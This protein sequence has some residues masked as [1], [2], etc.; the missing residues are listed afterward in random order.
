LRTRRDIEA[1]AVYDIETEGWSKFLVGGWF[2][3]KTYLE[4]DWT[5]EEE[6]RAIVW[7]GPSPTW[8]HNGGVFDH[9]WALDG[10]R[11]APV[12]TR[13]R[14]AGSRLVE[15]RRGDQRLLD[16]KAIAKLSLDR[17]TSGLGVT[18]L[19]QPLACDRREMH[20]PWCRG[21][22]RFRRGMLRTDFEKVREYLRADCESLWLALGRLRDWAAEHDLDLA[23]TIGS[24]AYADAR[25]LLDLPDSAFSMA[26]HLFCREAYFGGRVQV[27]RPELEEGE[28]Y[29]V[30]AMYPAA[31]A[32]LSLPWGMPEWVTGQRC[33]AAFDAGRP[34]IYSAR[35]S[36]PEVWIPVL[37]IRTAE[38]VAY[39]VGKFSGRWTQ[40]ELAYAEESG[41]AK[42]EE[43]TE[44]LVW[45]EERN[46][47]KPWIEKLW[48]LRATAE[49]GKSGPFGTFLKFY[50]NSLTG[51]LGTD[52]RTERIC[53][54]PAK[55]TLSMKP[56]GG[57]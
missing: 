13:F 28:A 43:V 26:E 3:G 50:M 30:S 8:A 6:F 53:R 7:N 12:E 35:V 5:K 38:R 52:P 48:S 44:A 42:I 39:P 41:R 51:K 40:I 46:V 24:A 55:V 37:P 17:F 34:G 49:G 57:G 23:P 32:S 22:C 19:E 4:R 45:P 29:D 36:V 54:D 16:S 10:G 20:G 14:C 47:F 18:K 25:R 11:G 21:Y 31:L 56:L 9:K 33:R 27:F 2:N 1:G 15:V